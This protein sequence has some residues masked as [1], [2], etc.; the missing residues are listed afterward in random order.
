MKLARQYYE[1][2]GQNERTEFIARRQSYHGATLG[3]L[4][5]SGHKTRRGIYEP[6]LAVNVHHVSPCNEYR[7]KE[8]GVSRKS[9]IERL[10]NELRDEF[11]RIGER[12]VI[13]F[14]VE[15]VVG[16][17]SRLSEIIGRVRRSLGTQSG[18]RGQSSVQR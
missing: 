17:V 16:A 1:V 4:S 12:R 10:A 6:I 9:Y 14:V 7:G 3:A 8:A 18:P 13:G 15:P 11:K 2:R 5:L